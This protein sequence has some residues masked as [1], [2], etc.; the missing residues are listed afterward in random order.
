MVFGDD[1]RDDLVGGE[2][3]HRLGLYDG[4]K[5]LHTAGLEVLDGLFHGVKSA[6]VHERDQAHADDYYL[7]VFGNGLHDVFELVD[8]AEEDRA[9]ET[10]DVNLVGD[11][12]GHAAFVAPGAFLVEVGHLLAAV[13]ALDEVGGALH[14]EHA[15]NDHA[16]ADGGEE[17]DKDGDQEDYDEHHGVGARN[18]GQVLETADIDDAHADGDEDASENGERHIFDHRT[19]SEHDSQQQQRVDH[20]GELCAAA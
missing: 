11:G 16:D 4:H 15:G 20:A 9:V 10:L 14:E 18:L 19:E 13:A 6:L 17:V 1:A 7:G 12:V 8:G 2:H 5:H 3:V